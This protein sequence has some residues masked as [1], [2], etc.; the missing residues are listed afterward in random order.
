MTEAKETQQVSC[1][2]VTP[3]KA[4]VGG[5][6]SVLLRFPAIEPAPVLATTLDDD[7]R[8]EQSLLAEILNT[9][10]PPHPDDKRGNSGQYNTQVRI[11]SIQEALTAITEKLF[12]AIFIDFRIANGSE[13]F[14]EPLAIIDEFNREAP[15]VSLIALLEEEQ[16]S[17]V[18]KLLARGISDYILDSEIDS[19]TVNRVLRY[20]LSRKQTTNQIFSLLHIDELTGLSNRH[21]CYDRISQ[22]MI[23]AERSGQN[24]A[25]L[26]IDLDNFHGIN[27]TLGYDVG[28]YLL[29]ETAKRLVNCVR[30]QDTVSRFGSDEF[31]L[32][33][34]GLNDP[35][36]A[37]V[38]AKQI[39]QNF[40]EP[41]FTQNQPVFISMSIG[42]SV[43][44]PEL[45][46]GR[47]LLK[48]AD[49]A[50]Y[51]AKENGGSNFQYFTPS[52]NSEA[53]KRLTLE[54]ELNYALKKIFNRK[55]GTDSLPDQDSAQGE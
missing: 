44:E 43:S 31:V 26:L 42:I 41:V 28:D 16:A 54:R 55:G 52:L 51:R 7:A 25:V 40:T 32:V 20:A 17:E 34:E 37:T 1:L 9:E 22:A 38:I 12:D 18:D 8:E 6:L 24:V 5:L 30:R 13:N 50:R 14:S 15:G 11:A 47:T 33:L 39:L 35:Q 29:K 3:T 4:Q 46:D 49:V 45:L 2:V 19:N 23:R 53:Q 48:Q 21:L 36:H 10:M 27:E